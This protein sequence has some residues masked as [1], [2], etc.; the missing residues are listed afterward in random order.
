[1]T[2]SGFGHSSFLQCTLTYVSCLAIILRILVTDLTPKS[3]NVDAAK[4]SRITAKMHGALYR[5]K[6]RGGA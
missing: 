5:R 1:M 2:T 6:L 4:H 3:L